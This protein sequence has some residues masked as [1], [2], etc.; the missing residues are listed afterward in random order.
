MIYTNCYYNFNPAVFLRK[1]HH[2]LKFSTKTKAKFRRRTSHEQNRVQMRKILCS[3]SLAFDSAHVKYGVWTWPI[4]GR[5]FPEIK[6][7]TTWVL[8][9]VKDWNLARHLGKTYCVRKCKKIFISRIGLQ[10]H[11]KAFPGLPNSTWFNFHSSLFLQLMF[12]IYFLI[13]CWCI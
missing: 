8:M 11:F 1:W 7:Q 2:F 4:G 10:G 13:T 9:L 12:L 3:P 6:V 5:E